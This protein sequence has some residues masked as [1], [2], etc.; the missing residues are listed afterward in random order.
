[1]I[2]VD[3]KIADGLDRLAPDDPD[4]R[5]DWRDVLT[6]AGVSSP[7]RQT[8]ALRLAAPALALV[9]GLG[10][11]AVVLTRAP[12]GGS[13]G[14][15]ACAALARYHGAIYIGQAV[16][17]APVAAGA[18]G[19]AVVP[20]CADTPGGASGPQTIRVLRI[21]GVPPHVALIWAGID[22]VVLVRR[23]LGSHLPKAL[24]RLLEAPSCRS[25]DAP[26]KLRGP[27]DGI[28]G[29]NGKTEVD[30][31]PPYDVTMKVAGASS[32]RYL[33]AFLT[34]RVPAALG[35]PLSGTDIHRSL[36]KGGTIAITATCAGGR[37]VA[38]RVRAFPPGA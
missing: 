13:G 22:D 24:R 19:T 10:V 15:G 38:Q 14:A 26:I 25:G 27:W 34:V 31:R 23:S 5:P 21:R 18:A 3:P 37:Y 30:L 35:R 4:A 2:D 7:S 11:A 17:I 12:T 16:H 29:A 20:S 8:W 1:M 36:G 33:H 6:R 32:R 28:L 9:I